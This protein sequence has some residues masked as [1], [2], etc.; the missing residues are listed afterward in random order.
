MQEKERITLFTMDIGGKILRYILVNC[1]SL[2]D[3]YSNKVNLIINIPTVMA[4]F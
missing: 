3:K 4:V 1:V 2:F